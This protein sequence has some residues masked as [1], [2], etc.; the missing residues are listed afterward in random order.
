MAIR[1]FLLVLTAAAAVSLV[2]MRGGG[3]GL[4]PQRLAVLAVSRSAARRID[5]LPAAEACIQPMAGHTIARA[6]KAEDRRTSEPWLWFPYA[7][8]R[9]IATIWT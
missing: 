6:A 3:T 9:T 8:T 7:C 4:L 2:V 5:L 1:I